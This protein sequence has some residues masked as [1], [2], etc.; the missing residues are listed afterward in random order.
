[1]RCENAAAAASRVLRCH[2]LVK[3]GWFVKTGSGRIDRRNT[4]TPKWPRALQVYTATNPD[5]PW[6]T[7]KTNGVDYNNPTLVPRPDG[8]YLRKQPFLTIIFIYL[9]T[10][11]EKSSFCQDRL[12]TDI[13]KLNK[14]LAAALC[15]TVTTV[16]TTPFLTATRCDSAFLARRFL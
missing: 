16:R 6:V 8:R 5:G 10:R 3:T 12:G 4:H 13:G 14:T 1:M 7:A 2:V 15:F 11:Y 9:Y